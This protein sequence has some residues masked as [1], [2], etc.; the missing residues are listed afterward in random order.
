VARARQVYTAAERR[1]L[2]DRWRAGES[3]SDIARALDRAPGTIHCTLRE[4]GGVAPPERRR[5]QRAL[6]VAEREEISRGIAAGQS[7]R[8][9]A[10]RLGRAPSTIS[11]EVARNGGRHRY[12]ASQADRRAWDA[13]RRPQACKLARNRVL[14]ELVAAKLAE[15]W[16]P[17]QIA[18]W[19][20]VQ[21][22]D[23]PEMQVS[24]ETIYLTLLIQARGA[25][26]RELVA[27]LRR[28]RSV[29]RPKG[30][31]SNSRGQGQIVDAV[32]IRERPPEAEDRAVP[33]HW[34]GDLLAGAANTHIATL[35]ERS[36]RFALL[37]KV[38]GKDAHTVLDALTA[39]VKE[40]PG[41]LR[42]SL[43][44]DRGTELAHHKQFTIATDVAVYFCDPQSPWQRGTGENTNGL[45]RQYLPK[46]TDLSAYSQDELDLIALKLNTRPRK[47][48]GYLTPAATLED[49]L[50]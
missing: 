17:Q 21:N 35:V 50:R 27:H 25:L 11:R 1:Q 32:S 42:R 12:R 19:L 34:E 33:G 15:D 9:I 43:T 44:W 20:K 47:T 24:H 16:S 48:L 45:L 22:P 3:V 46:G 4:R 6:S 5:A 40:L 31:L 10:R 30:A 2:W 26:K 29:R 14:R 18:G 8:L 49:V 37:V 23:E 38:D 36:S 7:G 13:A 41:E 39:K 28:V